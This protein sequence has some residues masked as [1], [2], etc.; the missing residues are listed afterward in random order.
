[1]Q[2]SAFLLLS[3]EHFI[4]ILLVNQILYLEQLT[5]AYRKYLSTFHCEQKNNLNTKRTYKTFAD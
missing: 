1:M 5:H 4:K 2:S 3:M